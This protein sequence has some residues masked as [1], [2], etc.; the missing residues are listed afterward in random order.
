MKINKNLY[1]YLFY[2]QI[3]EKN[4]AKQQITNEIEVA[5]YKWIQI[6]RKCQLI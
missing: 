2:T 6:C 4:K 5:D 1:Y 3:G